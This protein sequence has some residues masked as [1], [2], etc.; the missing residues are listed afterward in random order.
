MNLNQRP[1]ECVK[2]YADSLRKTIRLL[3]FVSTTPKGRMLP[4]MGGHRLTCITGL[5]PSR[6]SILGPGFDMV[7]NEFVESRDSQSFEFSIKWRHDKKHLKQG[8]NA[9]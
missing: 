8:R 4:W 6:K 2:L 9:P 5:R 3:T 1:V 7:K